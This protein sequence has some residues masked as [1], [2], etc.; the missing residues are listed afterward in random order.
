MSQGLPYDVAHQEALKWYNM[1]PY[2]VYS[3]EIIEM[4]LEYFN[5]NWIDYWENSR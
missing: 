1:L 2:A 4:N 5:E 3:R